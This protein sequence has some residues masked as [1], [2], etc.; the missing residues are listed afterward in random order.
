MTEGVKLSLRQAARIAE[1]IKIM[2]LQQ[3]VLHEV[4]RNG[5]GL[6]HDSFSP[7]VAGQQPAG[8]LEDIVRKRRSSV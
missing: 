7:V 4:G 6:I 2:L 8:L 1:A 3:Q 5:A